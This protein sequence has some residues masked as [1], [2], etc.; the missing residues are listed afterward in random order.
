MWQAKLE[1]EMRECERR[2]EEVLE[3]EAQASQMAT[4]LNDRLEAAHQNAADH[5]TAL[6]VSPTS[7]AVQ[8]REGSIFKKCGFMREIKRKVCRRLDTVLA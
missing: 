6:K 4:S 7:T 3:V 5:S 2:R 8:S 1:A